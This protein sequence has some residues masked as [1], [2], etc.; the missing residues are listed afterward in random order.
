METSAAMVQSAVEEAA[1]TY[2]KWFANGDPSWYESKTRQ[3]FIDP[4]LRAL[5]D[6]PL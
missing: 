4:I 1:V 5:V 6:Q 2:A 3:A